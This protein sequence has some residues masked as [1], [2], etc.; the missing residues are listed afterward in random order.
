MTVS[1]VLPGILLMCVTALAVAQDGISEQQKLLARRAAEAD[2]YR[3]LAETVYG[4]EI[5]SRTYVKDF[6]AE[7]DDIRG[8][9]DTFVKGIRL[10][11]PRWYEDGSCEVPAEVT[12]AK[13]IETLVSAHARHYKGNS[14]K[15]SDFE[16]ITA[17]TEKQVI[18]VIG[19]GAP[20]DADRIAGGGGDVDSGPAPAASGGAI[21]D[22]WRRVGPQARLM[23][24][25]AARMD[26]FRRLAERVKGLRLTSQTQVR[27]FVT[28]SDVITTE[29][30][31]DLVGATEAGVFLSPT[32]LI[33]EVRLVLPTEQV[34]T[35]IKKLHSRHYKGNDVKASQIEDIVRTVVKKEFEAVGQ[36]VPPQRFMRQYAEQTGVELPDWAGGAISAV[37]EGT[38]PEFGSPQGRLKA[39]R[40]AEMDARRKLAERIAGLRLTGST[41]VSDFATVADHIS[42]Q[43]SAVIVDSVVTST[44]FTED[45]A[46]VT[47]ELPG[48]R[49]WSIISV[50]QRRIK[51]SGGGN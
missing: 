51:I 30:Q 2:A 49:V 46:Q 39:A 40:A 13:V 50:E 5:N 11:T 47:V 3:K 44:R 23:A 16:S 38:D 4:I 26:A 31:A 17:R 21:P 43:V 36:G 27:D 1:R 7:S 18:K 25:R 22:N 10:G 14:I 42:S 29:L 8:D 19:M 37:G 41:T 12:V 9:L 48:A 34:I 24:I 32:E 15:A 28:E 45:T 6:V 35:T 20:R 33:A